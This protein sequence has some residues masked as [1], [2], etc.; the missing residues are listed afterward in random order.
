MSTALVCSAALCGWS[1]SISQH[2]WLP[3][4]C[5]YLSLVHSTINTGAETLKR[6]LQKKHANQDQ[7]SADQQEFGFKR[8]DIVDAGHA[9][10]KTLNRLD[11]ELNEIL[12]NVLKEENRQRLLMQSLLKLIDKNKDQF[13]SAEEINEAEENDWIGIMAAN[14]KDKDH[15]M[16]PVS[17]YSPTFARQGS[18]RSMSMKITRQ[19]TANSLGLNLSPNESG[20]QSPVPLLS[21]PP[22]Q[23]QRPLLRAS[24][25][26]KLPSQLSSANNSSNGLSDAM[27]NNVNVP[28]LMINTSHGGAPF[29]ANTAAKT[30]ANRM[31][32]SAS[33]IAL[34][35]GFAILGSDLNKKCDV[36]VQVDEKDE[37]GCKLH[38]S[39][40]L[41]LP[42]LT[43]DGVP[44]EFF[45]VCH[46]TDYFQ[47]I[48]TVAQVSTRSPAS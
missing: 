9:Q 45:L 38:A 48:F 2:L 5:T 19:G 27:T 40:L 16:S 25:S 44:Q 12:A 7:V 29:V 23:V 14:R 33:M 34:T 37:F 11:V 35:T 21:A 42:W 26:A 32:R 17:T 24:L 18:N 41:F 10:L 1:L 4:A 20:A 46:R 22:V 15:A 39:F 3:R 31:T 6:G 8:K 30:P 43:L 36:G 13:F 47:N 28:A